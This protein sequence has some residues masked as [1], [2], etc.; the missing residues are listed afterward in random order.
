MLTTGTIK[1]LCKICTWFQSK[2]VNQHCFYRLY[3]LPAGQPTV[4]TVKV[5]N[6][7]HLINVFNISAAVNCVV[8]CLPWPPRSLVPGSPNQLHHAIGA[9]RHQRS[10]EA[11]EDV[12]RMC[13]K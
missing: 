9:S 4:L 11:T 12:V 3:A 10:W 7:F 13:E 1:L 8:N 5:L 6:F 2:S